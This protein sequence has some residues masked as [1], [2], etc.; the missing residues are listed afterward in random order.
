MRALSAPVTA[1]ALLA[2]L[3]FAQPARSQAQSPVLA[4]K[5]VSDAEGPMEGVLV[6][7]RKNGA[8]ITVT[9][10]SDADG[11][12]RFP[13]SRLDPGQYTLTIRAAGYA[14]DSMPNIEIAPGRPTVA[15]LKLKPAQPRHDQ[16]ANAE[17][18]MSA[19]APTRSNG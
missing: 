7:A 16:I 2:S 18:I 4:G 19:P 17:W 3:A 8:T 11:E 1:M 14:L 9:V 12:Y 6:S 10:A 15:D 5:V 13:A